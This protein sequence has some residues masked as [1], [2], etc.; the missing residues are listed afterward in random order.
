M[1][2]PSA[3]INYRHFMG[4]HYHPHRQQQYNRRNMNFQH[5]SFNFPP[6]PSISSASMFNPA[7]ASMMMPSTTTTNSPPSPFTL[8]SN[9]S[10]KEETTREVFFRVLSESLKEA[11]KFF[12]G[13]TTSW[14][15][16]F[17]YKTTLC[18]NYSNRSYC[19]FG[20]NCWYAHGNHELR[21]IPESEELPEPAFIKQ[22]L[23]FLGLP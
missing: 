12:C 19:R 21:C 7:A 4:N 16:P 14:K 20:V 13:K 11:N 8:S 9:G 22:Y 18:V 3:A 15:N 2:N 17:L 23:S 6:L 1:S 10:A 5:S